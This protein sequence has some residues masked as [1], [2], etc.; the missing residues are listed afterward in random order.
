MF[1]HSLVNHCLWVEKRCFSAFLKEPDVDALLKPLEEILFGSVEFRVGVGRGLGEL[2]KGDFSKNGVL[3]DFV[4]N[5]CK[6]RILT[7]P[8]ERSFVNGKA[9]LCINLEG[10]FNGVCG[11]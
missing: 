4:F 6:G 1:A 10:D 2:S 7:E 9:E 3:E 8:F 5:R 11:G